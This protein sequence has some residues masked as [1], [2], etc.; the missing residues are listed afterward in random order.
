MMDAGTPPAMANSAPEITAPRLAETLERAVAAT[1][2]DAQRVKALEE[3]VKELE[4][5]LGRA[6]VAVG[7]GGNGG[8]MDSVVVEALREEWAEGL[9][10]LERRLDGLEAAGAVGR[11]GGDGSRRA[12]AQSG[13]ERR[14]ADVV[15]REP[16]DDD[17]QVYGA[18][19]ELV[20][21]WRGLW[22]GHSAT[23]RGLAW[24]SVRQRILEVEVSLLEEHGLTLPQETEPLR[25]LDRN[26]QLS[27]RQRELAGVRRRRN[28]LELL[29]WARRVL[30]LGLCRR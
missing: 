1:G 4:Q 7:S 15:T 18:A 10:R 21:E 8:D 13:A 3:R 16:A 12:A 19:W 6:L 20:D 23:G 29:R 25:G 5:Q 26:E 2:Q 28:R 9:R 30:T 24:V 17:E 27:W 14:Y 22:A 11:R